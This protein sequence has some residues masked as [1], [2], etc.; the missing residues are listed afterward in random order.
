MDERQ[1]RWER[2]GLEGWAQHALTEPAVAAVDILHLDIDAILRTLEVRECA[3]PEPE[4]RS[5]TARGPHPCNEQ[6][7]DWCLLRVGERD[8][9]ADLRRHHRMY[10]LVTS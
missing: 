2:D 3:K 8:M 7:T 5:L 10:E 9:R 4:R 1:V 6:I